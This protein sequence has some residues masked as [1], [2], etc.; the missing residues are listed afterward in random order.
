MN[1]L[2]IAHFDAGAA[3]GNGLAVLRAG[4]ILGGDLAHVWTGTYQREGDSLCAR[5][6]VSPCDESPAPADESGR[7][8][9]PWMAT[10]SGSCSGGDAWLSGH[11][12]NSDLPLNV[13]LHRAA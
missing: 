8:E 10:L 2:W 7:T 3:H 12:D 5:I 13:R 11:P 1:G 9:K 6:Q 4:D